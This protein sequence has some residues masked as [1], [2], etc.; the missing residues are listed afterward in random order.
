MLVQGG[1]VAGSLADRIEKEQWEKGNNKGK[2]KRLAVPILLFLSSKL[3]AYTLLGF[4]LGAIGSVLSLSSTTRG[5]MQIAIAVFMI[6]N[7]LRMLNVHPIFRYFSFEPPA[8]IT[9]YIRRRSKAKDSVFTPLFLG[10]LTVFIPCGVTQSMMALAIASGSAADRRGDHVRLHPGRQPG[11]LRPNYLATAL[12]SLAE[13][14][15]TR[16]AAV[17]L[18]LFGVITLETGLNLTGSPVTLSA[19]PAAAM[20]VFQPSSPVAVEQALPK[21]AGPQAD[22]PAASASSSGAHLVTINAKNNGYSPSQLIAPAGEVVDLSI[23]TKKTRSCSRAFEIPALGY[24]V[25]LPE[26]GEE[27]V[28]IPPQPA[29]P[30]CASPA[31]WACTPASSTSNE[32]VMTSLKLRIPDMHCSACAM[33]L[34]GIEGDLP[35]IQ[36]IKA[37][38]HRQTLEV[39]YDES[40][41]SEERILQ[42]VEQLGYTSE[43]A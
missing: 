39:E 12:G 20:R 29:A 37:S 9:R 27:K 15:F 33:K 41:V 2:R 18:L 11:V 13:K 7:G 26:T 17:A 38:Y 3:V 10:A 40:R 19:I 16:I 34:E 36:K 4:L 31:R 22:I 23:V 32:P 6:G 25:L 30:S 14:Y 43:P 5:I 42:A 21:P 24:S 28:Q 8:F 1:L 35:G